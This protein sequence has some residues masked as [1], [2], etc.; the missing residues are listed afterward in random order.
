MFAGAVFLQI[1]AEKFQS[2]HQAE[3][4]SEGKELDNLL[5][6][7]AQLCNFK[8]R[9]R[10]LRSGQGFILPPPVGKKVKDMFLYSVL[11]RLKAIYPTY[12]L[13][14]LLITTPIRLLWEALRHSEII[15][16]R[17]FTHISTAIRKASEMD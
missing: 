7:L 9:T 11:S 3:D 13:A 1:W 14:D 17:L 10:L 2:L 4:E 12:R 8:V 5:V 15:A 16:R 6:L